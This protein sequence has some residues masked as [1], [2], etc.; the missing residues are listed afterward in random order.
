MVASQIPPFSKKLKLDDFPNN[1]RGKDPRSL[2]RGSVLKFPGLFCTRILGGAVPLWAFAK[3]QRLDVQVEQEVTSGTAGLDV[4]TSVF[5][6]TRP[7]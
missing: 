7:K 3:Q 4:G 5:H 1:A 2:P 6:K